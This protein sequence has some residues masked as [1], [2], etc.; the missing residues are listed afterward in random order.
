MSK[1]VRK[2]PLGL[3]LHVPV[4]ILMPDGAE[5]LHVGTQILIASHHIVHEDVSPSL[6]RPYV[7]ALVDALVDRV[8][9]RGFV[10]VGTGE[11]FNAEGSKFIG[12][13]VTS[14]LNMLHV[15]ELER[16]G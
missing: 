11:E 4:E 5:V 16:A 9:R 14:D 12:T 15:F 10:I 6:E 1:I 7:W 3:E 8:V 13:V 2:Y